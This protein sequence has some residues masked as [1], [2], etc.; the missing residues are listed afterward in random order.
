MLSSKRRTEEVYRAQHQKLWRALFAF[1]GD[2]DLASDA[3]AEAFAQLLGRGD[4]VRDP[5][6]WVWRSAFRIAAGLHPREH[7][8]AHDTQASEEVQPSTVE[9]LSLLGDLSD[10][11]RACVVLKYVGMFRAVEVA[12]L[13]DT[14]PETVRVQLHRAHCSLRRTLR[15]EGS[16]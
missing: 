11:Q 10:Q 6:A 3:E 12:E 9:F 13:L 7:Q 1:T 2:R 16:V 14:S 15:P 4:E 8:L 5:A